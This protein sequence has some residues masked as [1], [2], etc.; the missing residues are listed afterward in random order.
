PGSSEGKN[1]MTVL[2]RLSG[3]RAG[4]PDGVVFQFRAE[5]SVQQ[6]GVSAGDPFV[7]VGCE[8]GRNS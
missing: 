1:L 7:I 6:G 8:C 4:F 2:N 5:A 3:C